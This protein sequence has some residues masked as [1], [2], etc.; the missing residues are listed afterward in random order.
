MNV[1]V[2]WSKLIWSGLMDDVRIYETAL[3]AE[4]VA[5]LAQQANQKM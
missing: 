1:E 4:E 2:S 3:S 5:D